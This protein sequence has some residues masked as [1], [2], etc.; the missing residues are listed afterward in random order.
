MQ[1]KDCLW[2][3]LGG[4]LGSLMRYGFTLLAAA[5]SLSGIIATLAANVCGSFL[6]GVVTALCGTHDHSLYP[7]L[8]VGLCGGFTTFST[9]SAQT[10]QMVQSGE[11]GGAAGYAAMSV[12]CCVVSVGAGMYVGRCLAR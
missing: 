11:W 5:F 9:F 3:A 6:I 7:L 8:A 12:I 2:V 4:A 1:W 10:L